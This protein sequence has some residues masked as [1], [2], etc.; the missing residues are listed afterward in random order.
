MKVTKK[1]SPSEYKERYGKHLMFTVHQRFQM[2]T[3]SPAHDGTKTMAVDWAGLGT[4]TFECTLTL[5]SIAA[6]AKQQKRGSSSNLAW[7][8]QKDTYQNPAT[9]RRVQGRRYSPQQLSRPA[10]KSTCLGQR[11]AVEPWLACWVQ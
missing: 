8:V 11:F 2:E 1:E 7:S 6:L 5:K 3:E 10:L 9:R 4:L